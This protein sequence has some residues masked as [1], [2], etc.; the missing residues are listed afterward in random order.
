M[1]HP[2]S[3]PPKEKEKTPLI[4][5]EEILG[6]NT[7]FLVEAREMK[8][9]SLVITDHPS[10]WQIVRQGDS[11]HDGTLDFQEFS[12]Y[13]RA[14]EKRLSLMFDNVDRNHDGENTLQ[15]H[16]ASTLLLKPFWTISPANKTWNVLFPIPSWADQIFKRRYNNNTN[17]YFTRLVSLRYKISFP[18]ETR[19][20]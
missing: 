17:L 16:G 3:K 1:T 19:S 9:G 11:N 4:S 8:P 18:R 12:E 2:D 7:E 10:L 15:N 14:N 20:R 6:R 5:K 13:L